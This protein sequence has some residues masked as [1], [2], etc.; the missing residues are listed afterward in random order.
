MPYQL[1]VNGQ[2]TDATGG[3]T[4]DVTNP[5]TGEVVASYAHGDVVDAM[6]AMDAAAAAFVD[7]RTTTAYERAECLHRSAAAIRERAPEIARV[8]TLENGKTLPE[9]T[10]ETVGCAGWLDWFAEEGKRVY[11][12]MIPSQFGHKRHWVMRQPVGVVVAVN[13][14]NFPINLMSRKLGAALAAGCTVICRP[15]TQAPLSAMLL[16]ECLG[17]AGFPPGAIGLVTGVADAIVPAL[18]EHR[19]CRKLAFTGSTEVGR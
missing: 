10:A 5:A 4:L 11:G 16:F 17:D 9:S 8:L 1:Y 2:W 15:A 18:L 19:A 7:W 13:P 3:K 6:T 14:W 12:R